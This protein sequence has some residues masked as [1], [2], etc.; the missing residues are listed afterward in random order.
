[1]QAEEIT[2]KI[3]SGEYLTTEL[4]I[5][6][7]AQV[8]IPVSKFIVPSC[9][10]SAVC[11]APWFQIA[12]YRYAISTYY[13]FTRSIILIIETHYL[14]SSLSNNMTCKPNTRAGSTNSQFSLSF[15]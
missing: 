3:C 8:K 15:S 1:M 12:L 7:E 10:E 14:V 6:E 5:N 4:A 13:Y 9:R 2:V 11:R